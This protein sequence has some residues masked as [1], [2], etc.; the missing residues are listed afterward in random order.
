MS[1]LGFCV[2]SLAGLNKFPK[3]SMLKQNDSDWNNKMIKKYEPTYP[4]L[5][6]LPWLLGPPDRDPGALAALDL[7]DSYVTAHFK[8]LPVLC[9]SRHVAQ[10]AALRQLPAVGCYKSDN[11]SRHVQQGSKIHGQFAIHNIPCCRLACFASVNELFTFSIVVFK[12]KCI[13][14]DDRELRYGG[15]VACHY[16]IM[17]L[18][19]S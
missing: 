1:D 5:L 3:S 15:S 19:F 10:T 14:V 4:W 12:C 8:M 18:E 6:G 11:M 7:A 2:K 13:G 16:I 17:L 9:F